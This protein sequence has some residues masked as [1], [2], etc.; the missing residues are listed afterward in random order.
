MKTDTKRTTG[1]LL[2][3]ARR[4]AGVRTMTYT[5]GSK[6]QSGSK[7]RGTKVHHI[8]FEAGE[9]IVVHSHDKEALALLLLNWC[10]I[11]H[12]GISLVAFGGRRGFNIKCVPQSTT[13]PKES[14]GPHNSSTE[15]A[16]DAA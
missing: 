6:E 12:T 4:H 9:T 8:A 7:E 16:G 13:H 3:E 11:K 2:S 15:C 10:G 14:N 1:L 5:S